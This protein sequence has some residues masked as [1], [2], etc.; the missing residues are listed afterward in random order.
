M[1]NNT[2]ISCR[3]CGRSNFKSERGLTQH[4]QQSRICRPQCEAQGHQLTL[5]AGNDID[6][7]VPPNV[8]DHFP[9]NFSQQEIEED[10]EIVLDNHGNVNHEVD[11]VTAQ[12]AAFFDDH[13]DDATAAHESSSEDESL[14]PDNIQDEAEGLEEASGNS[15]QNDLQGSDGPNTNIRDQFIEYCDHMR[16]NHVDFSEDEKAAIELLDLLRKKNAPLNAHDDLMMW[17]LKQS[18]LAYDHETSRDNSHFIGRAVML[19][20]LEERC[21]MGNKK[22]YKKRIKLPVSG[23]TIEITCLGVEGAIQRLLT[24]PRITS[25]DYLFF[26]GNPRAGPPETLT[27][28]SDLNTG[29]AFLDTHDAKIDA[30]KGEQLLGIPLYIDGAS[31]SQFHQMEVISVKIGLAVMTREA[32]KKEYLWTS[33]GYVEHIVHSGARGDDILEEAFHLEHQ[34][35]INPDA[36]PA[37]QGRQMPGLGDHNCQDWHAMVSCILEDLVALQKHGFMWN[38]V[39]EQ[40]I[41]RDIH[42]ILFVPF[43]KCDN[44]EADTICGKY[45]D[46]TKSQQLCRACHILTQNANDHLAQLHLKT[47]PEIQRLVER[48]DIAGLKA[49]SQIYLLNAFHAL[50]FSVG[51]TRGVHGSCP[52]DMLHTIQLGIFKYLREVFFQYLGPTSEGAKQID[53][54][55]KIYCKLFGRQSDRSLPGT[56]FSNGIRGGGKMMAKE[57]R[58]ILLVMLAIFRST[59][60]RK[61]MD[62]YRS[63]KLNTTKD[64]WILLIELLLQWEAYLN[65]PSME[66][67]HLKRLQQK[68]RYLMY[69]MRKLAKRSAGMGLKL[70]KFHLILHLVEDIL[71]FGVPLEFDTAA[72]ESHHKEA[73]KA[74]RLTQRS[75]ATFQFQ[76]AIRMFEFHLVELAMHEI[77]TGLRLWEYFDGAVEEEE[78]QSQ[79]SQEAMGMETEGNAES[80]DVSN[81]SSA[82]RSEGSEMSVVNVQ[83]GETGITVWLEEDTPMFQLNTRSKATAA[84]TTWNSDVVT[85]L[86]ELQTKVEA[87]LPT[88]SMEIYTWHKRNDQIFRAHPNYRGKGPWRDWALINWGPGY[89]KLPGHIWCFVVLEGLPDQRSGINHG[90]IKHLKNGVYAVVES[91]SPEN[92][93]EDVTRSE[94]MM[95]VIKEVGDVNEEGAV[96]S[97]VM[98]LADTEAFAGPCTVVPDIGGPSNR[99]FVVKPRG[100]WAKQFTDW[101]EQPH[102]FD[103]IDPL[104]SDEEDSD[105]SGNDT[106]SVASASEEAE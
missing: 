24:D 45:Q 36:T 95:P 64:D 5:D 84:S 27:E 25:G 2:V 54:L 93:D 76:T 22:P 97:R 37:H 104:S 98:Y 66:V 90:G 86:V 62:K 88:E 101:V 52:A 6:G 100:E 1:A 63:F 32:R 10:P 92:N 69:L 51:N 16:D 46:R 14:Q 77:E 65:E 49:I 13:F 99:Y 31:I 55:A 96:T 58:G 3:F 61:I 26:D 8:D 91:A 43:I 83:T 7:G 50:R 47:V 28:V 94:L 68:H 103:E 9:S 4:W 23:T 75:A 20:R 40:K 73:K 56:G 33:L 34:D 48:G 15:G 82:E 42:Y 44:K 19:K 38:M 29:K 72:N 12:I 35:T 87:F 41:Y 53:A 11:A 80:P 85:F 74:A 39:Y 18:G 106:N 105:D 70:V 30:G 21:N 57:Y 81:G 89:G 71:Q 17:H 59:K 79:S 102:R 78:T 60:G 67:Y